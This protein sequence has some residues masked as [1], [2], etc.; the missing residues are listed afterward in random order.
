M[1][2]ISAIWL[3][4]WEARVKQSLLVDLGDQELSQRLA[5]TSLFPV[6]LLGVHLEDGQ[7]GTLDI[8]QNL[9]LHNH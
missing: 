1:K 5:V 2:S 6:V 9:R 8:L 4:R 7:L 3:Q